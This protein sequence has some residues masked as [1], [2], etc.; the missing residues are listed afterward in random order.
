[1]TPQ[2]PYGVPAPH[3]FDYLTPCG[4]PPPEKRRTG[5][6]VGLSVAMVLVLS[7]AAL[8]II[9]ADRKRKEARN[10]SG[11]ARTLIAP[12]A[13]GDYKVVIGN[14]ADRVAESMK[15]AMTGKGAS[16]DLYAHAR[17]GIYSKG[18]AD[19]P[20]L[21]FLGMSTTD[22]PALATA[23][24]ITSQSGQVDSAFLGAGIKH[25]IDFPAGPL[26][27][28]M[29]CG[30]RDV[31]TTLHMCVWADHATLGLVLPIEATDDAGAASIAVTFRGDAEH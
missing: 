16:T 26:G 18:V 5:L 29:R 17:I 31:G 2:Q 11:P 25:A 12:T 21:I 3:Q 9:G 13:S 14:V 6:I 28:I 23:L 1:M 7:L 4:Y 19:D 22:T 15:S 8:G 30:H 24:R 27:G 10:L 20:T